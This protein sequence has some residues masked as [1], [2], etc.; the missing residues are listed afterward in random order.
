[1]EHFP[2]P[3]AWGNHE[4][5]TLILPPT[6]IFQRKCQTIAKY[7]YNKPLIFLMMNALIFLTSKVVN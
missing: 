1:M 2:E 5:H 6:L 4:T 3:V 7:T